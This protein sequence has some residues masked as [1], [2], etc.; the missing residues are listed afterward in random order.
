M[1]QPA[2]VRTSAQIIPFPGAAAAPVVNPKR[3]PGRPPKNVISIWKGRFLRKQREH[4]AREAARLNKPIP[5]S[6]PW[7]TGRGA[8]PF[9]KVSRQDFNHLNDGDRMGIEATMVGLVTLR[10]AEARDG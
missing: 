8:W 2:S 10:K 1:A 3:G 4:E 5:I 7:P 9:L 6:H